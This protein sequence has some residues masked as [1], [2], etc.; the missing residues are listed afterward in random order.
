MEAEMA[1]PPK[2]VDTVTSCSHCPHYSYDSGNVN[3]C[4]LVGEVVR[5]KTIVAPFCPLPDYPSR[6]IAEMQM[7]IAGLRD[8]LKYSF[9]LTLLTYV[10]NRL[11]LNLHANGS[12]IIIPFKDM[13]KDREAYL[14]LDLIRGI[15]LRPFEITFLSSDGD[16][17]L[18]PDG[19]PP[20]LREAADKDGK[21]WYHHT[22]VV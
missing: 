17:K 16:F 9:G 18:A 8:P 1:Y 20:L 22:L 5:D 13:K 11:K 12:G 14:G 21:N 4:S 19:D 7:T 2:V 10:A 3:R 15:E 6:L